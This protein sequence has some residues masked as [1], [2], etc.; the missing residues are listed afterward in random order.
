MR[1]SWLTLATNSR[2][3]FCAAS[4][5]VTSWSTTSAPPAGS[6]AALISK[7]RPGASRLARPMQSSPLLERAAHA[8]QQL[9]IAHGVDER[10]AG[11]ESAFRQCAA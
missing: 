8:G 9:G 3:D 5:L 4:M 11:D 7:T 6:G 1:S 2:R 10:A